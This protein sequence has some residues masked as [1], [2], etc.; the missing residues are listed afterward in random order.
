MSS[1]LRTAPNL[2][3]IRLATPEYTMKNSLALPLLVNRAAAPGE[4]WYHLIP[5][6]EF[7]HAESGLTQ[8]LDDAA[9]TSIVNRFVA[10]SNV[11][12]FRG[13]LVD[14]EH[15]S[16]DPSKSSE[17]FGWIR[18]L[19][20]RDDG[21]WGRIDWTDLGAAALTAKRYKSISPVWFPRDVAVVEGKRVR[22]MRLDSAGLTNTPNLEG[23][24]PLTNRISGSENAKPDAGPIDKSIPA[25]GRALGLSGKVT[26]DRILTAIGKLSDRCRQAE[27]HAKLQAELMADEDLEP[28]KNRM[29]PVVIASLRAQLISNR[30]LALPIVHALAKQ[31][32]APPLTNRKTAGNPGMRPG[33]PMEDTDPSDEVAQEIKREI[34]TIMSNRKCTYAEARAVLRNQRPHLFRSRH[35]GE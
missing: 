19:Q 26:S 16:Y 1:N 25:I 3:P 8:G 13:L 6:G 17:A 34:G 5:K 29:S 31:P 11:P 4:G 21:I 18:E 14:Q 12:D 15:F 20:S 23:M 33:G 30:L 27:E 10:E 24:V 35:R 9:L 22:P 2:A 7:L 28:I 32:P